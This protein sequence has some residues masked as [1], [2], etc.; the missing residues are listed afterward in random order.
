M[1]S[2]IPSNGH[3]HD[4]LLLSELH[5]LTSSTKDLVHWRLTLERRVLRL[6]YGL[7]THHQLNHEQTGSSQMFGLPLVQLLW[8]WNIAGKYCLDSYPILVVFWP[9]CLQPL[10]FLWN[11]LY[12]DHGILWSRKGKFNGAYRSPPIMF[13]SAQQ[14]SNH[15]SCTLILMIW[16]VKIVSL[17]VVVCHYVSPSWT[18]RRNLATLKLQYVYLL[19]L[20]SCSSIATLLSLLI[21]CHGLLLGRGI[22]RTS[23]SIGICIANLDRFSLLWH[24]PYSEY[25]S[26][27]RVLKQSTAHD[28]HTD[29]PSLLF[30]LSTRQTPATLIIV[31]ILRWISHT[32][33]MRQS[34]RNNFTERKTSQHSIL[35]TTY[36]SFHISQLFLQ[37]PIKS[38]AT[39]AD[40]LIEIVPDGDVILVVTKAERTLRFKVHSVFLRTASKVF[41]NLLS[42]KFAEGQALAIAAS[43]SSPCE[44]S[45]RDDDPEGMNLVLNI[46]HLQYNR[47]PERLTAKAAVSLAILVDKY[48][49]HDAIPFTFTKWIVPTEN[50]D[51]HA[52]LQT[53][54]LLGDNKLFMETTRL[55][56]LHQATSYSPKTCAGQDGMFLHT[57][58]K[59][60]SWFDSTSCRQLTEAH[61]QNRESK[62]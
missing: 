7:L 21:T 13:T 27:K 34:H 14:W 49:L 33:N 47:C 51:L 18:R 12:L 25:I 42:P 48:L 26:V 31:F 3:Q 9:E 46:I 17:S 54:I 10:L 52:F 19:L 44:I 6:C 1:P 61:S 58:C 24:E 40:E 36:I 30:A 4:F 45:L 50:D 28:I 53:A 8:V 32:T 60:Q 59:W 23:L 55:M 43:S 2:S 22:R 39:M 56:I 57:I 5:W 41:A 29:I 35:M 37:S 11:T 20:P 38:L 62:R 16:G 15:Q